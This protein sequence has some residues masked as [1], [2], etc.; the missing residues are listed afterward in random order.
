MRKAV[1]S[2]CDLCKDDPTK[3]PTRQFKAREISDDKE[4]KLLEFRDATME[5]DGF[6][7]F[8]TPY[9][10]EPDPSVK[11]Q[12]GFLTPSFGGSSTLGAHLTLPY[13]Q[14]LGPSADFT[15]TPR[16]T[17]QAGTVVAGDYRQRFS[18]GELDAIGSINYSNIGEGTTETVSHGWR[19]HINTIGVWD[20]DD[21]YRT[22]FELERVS[23]Q[24]YLRRFG[25]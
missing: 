7:V 1:Y 5:I 12:S 24:T 4:Q 19:G 8:Y 15:V 22:G 13:Y 3:P 9:L 6:P 18:N 2:P 25:F 20:L 10:S 17:T 16:F 11:R 21:T 23:D 14:V